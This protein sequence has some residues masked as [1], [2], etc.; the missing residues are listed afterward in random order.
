MLPQGLCSYRDS[1]GSGGGN[2]VS[3]SGIIP[4]QVVRCCLAP[5]FETKSITSRIALKCA[6]L[7]SADVQRSAN[8]RKPW[9]LG[10]WFTKP[11]HSS[12]ISCAATCVRSGGLSEWRRESILC[13]STHSLKDMVGSNPILAAN[14]FRFENPKSPYGIKMNVENV[15]DAELAQEPALVKS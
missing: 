4:G 7:Y 2:A 15:Q 9:N 5:F 1:V 6:A 11:A 3:S 12:A 13:E 10:E 8:L 14:P